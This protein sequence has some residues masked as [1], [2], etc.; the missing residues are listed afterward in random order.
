M[1]RK[2]LATA[3]LVALPCVLAFS[4]HA[5]EHLTAET[6]ALLKQTRLSEGVL[7]GLDRELA[8][9][10]RMTLDETEFAQVAKVFEAR[11]PDIKIEYTHGIGRERVLA[12]LLAFKRGTILSDVLFAVDSNEKD[13]REAKALVDL[14]DL[15][16]FQNVPPESRAK[17][18]LL[19]AAHMPHYCMSYNTRTVK[20]ED[21]PKTW[22]ELLTNPR[23]RNGKIGMAV[24]VHT[25]LAPLWG[26]KGD[27]WTDDYLKRLFTV[28]RP[29]LRKEQ[30][31]M[32]PR[33]N[34]MGE[35]DI[36]IPAGDYAVR[37]YEDKGL[38][39]SFHCPDI[40]AQRQ[41]SF[42]I[43]AGTPRLDAAK[44]FVNWALSKEG[45]I[46]LSHAG[47]IIP[48]HKDLQIPELLPYPKEVLGKRTA[49]ADD[50]VSDKTPAIIA[51]FNEYWTAERKAAGTAK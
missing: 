25:W 34:A 18:G 43:I 14:R 39:V 11:Y 9:K 16:G 17:D 37:P 5:A 24:N 38:P 41:S 15:P 8:V 42:V 47:Q 44:I 29:Q 12:P 4:A 2:R 20:K 48:S 33:L 28:V 35:F 1:N 3:A 50:R 49:N 6:R 7:K 27:A 23:W 13:L 21:L 31:S 36:S 40:V 45:Q 10:V 26:I 32:T 51:H 19:V 30:L 46:A 22:E